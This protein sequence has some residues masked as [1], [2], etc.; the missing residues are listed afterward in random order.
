MAT[1]PFVYPYLQS[2]FAG[3]DFDT[4]GD[5]PCAASHAPNCLVL[6]RLRLWRNEPHAQ[7]AGQRADR[8]GL[9]G[10]QCGVVEELVVGEAIGVERWHIDVD[11]VRA[12]VDLGESI[13]VATRDQTG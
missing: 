7:R 8:A 5:T 10:R 9:R 3:A 13:V 12:K 4:P 2:E 1:S 6:D 11:D